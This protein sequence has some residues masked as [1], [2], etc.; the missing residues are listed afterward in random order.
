MNKALRELVL[1]HA[2]R[3]RQ[4]AVDTNNRR[5]SPS[6]SCLNG[7]CAIASARLHRELAAAGV[8][9][10]I[11]MSGSDIGYHVYLV[12]NDH[13]VDITATQFFEYRKVEVLIL[14]IKEAE[15]HWFHQ[16]QDIFETADELRAHQIR[17]G[18]PKDQTAHAK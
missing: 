9:S 15:I 8:K 12:I 16:G 10:E 13:I 6:P 4:W 1:L 5:K 11:H 3:V 17:T 14:H 18:W 2:K 7:W